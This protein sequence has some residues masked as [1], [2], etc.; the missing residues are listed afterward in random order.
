M[1]TEE[2]Q[3]VQTTRV[4]RSKRTHFLTEQDVRAIRR[5]LREAPTQREVARRWGLSEPYVSQLKR[6]DRRAL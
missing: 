3:S 1:A 6:G 5:E 4:L 2:L